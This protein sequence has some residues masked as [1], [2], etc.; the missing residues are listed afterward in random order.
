MTS[1]AL[2]GS[3]RSHLREQRGVALAPR[4]AEGSRSRLREQ[5]GVP[6]AQGISESSDQQSD[7]RDGDA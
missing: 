6:L 2:R 7:E 5:G 4:G 1:P 3:L